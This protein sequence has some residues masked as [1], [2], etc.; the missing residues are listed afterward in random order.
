MSDPV[1]VFYEWM[2]SSGGSMFLPFLINILRGTTHSAASALSNEKTPI[3][4]PS[5]QFVPVLAH[6][7]VC[8]NDM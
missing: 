8:R 5:K 3:G 2:I 7:N 4:S 1:A 6:Q